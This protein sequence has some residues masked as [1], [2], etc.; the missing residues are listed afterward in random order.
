MRKVGEVLRDIEKLKSHY[1]TISGI[2]NKMAEDNDAGRYIS[3]TF[4]V[5][6][7]TMRGMASDILALAHRLK[8]NLEEIEVDIK[9]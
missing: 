1:N 7:H 6:A 4:G 9:M 5:Y 8:S 3:D 2:A